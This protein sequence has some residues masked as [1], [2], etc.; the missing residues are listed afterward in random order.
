MQCRNFTI[1][2]L[3]ALLFCLSPGI[4]WPEPSSTPI[5]SI[6]Q[7]D[8]QAIKDYTARLEA[9]LQSQ[10]PELESFR[11]NSQKLLKQL[12]TLQEQLAT[13][14]ITIADLQSRLALVGQNLQDLEKSYAESI[15]RIVGLEI[16][17]T[18]LWVGA[19]AL[20]VTTVVVIIYAILK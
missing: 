12:S 2:F 17:N 1:L 4:S 8:W 16:E 6:S 19:G 5:V 15:K 13:S 20:A 10:T 7:K 3:S 9:I 14:Q 18:A 11:L